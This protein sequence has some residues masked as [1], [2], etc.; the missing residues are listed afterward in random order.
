[1]VSVFFAGQYDH[2]LGPPQSQLN[3]TSN[4]AMEVDHSLGPSP[5]LDNHRSKRRG[6]Y[7]IPDNILRTSRNAINLSEK[8]MRWL[9]EGRFAIRERGGQV[10]RGLLLAR[11]QGSPIG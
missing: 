8:W 11:G 10:S 7:P 4:D 6:H 3:S 1:M 5:S 2:L 9:D